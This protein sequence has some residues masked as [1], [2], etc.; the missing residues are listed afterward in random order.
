[1]LL[2]VNNSKKEHQPNNSHNI[3]AKK[4]SNIKN[5]KNKSL[6]KLLY[7]NS[8]S[9]MQFKNTKSKLYKYNKK[10][11][12]KRNKSF[13][14]SISNFNIKDT[15]LSKNFEGFV[16]TNM[17][18]KTPKMKQR[19]NI[20][21]QINIKKQIKKEK[22]FFKK[23]RLKQLLT[24]IQDKR[25]NNSLGNKNASF[26]KYKSNVILKNNS[27]KNNLFLKE[28]VRSN[29]VINL[30]Y[31][32]NMKNN[33]SQN[34][35]SSFYQKS[36]KKQNITINRYL[37]NKN[38]K[39][40]KSNHKGKGNISYEKYSE[41]NSKIKLKKSLIIHNRINNCSNSRKRKNNSMILSEKQ[42]NLLK[43]L[44]KKNKN[45]YMKTNQGNSVY[46]KNN[47]CSQENIF[48][49][50]NYNNFINLNYIDKNYNINNI[51]I[52]NRQPN[53]KSY[54]KIN[55][56]IIN[57][58]ANHGFLQRR[59][60]NDLLDFL[61]MKIK[62]N[63][64]N[65]ST[66]QS[67]DEISLYELRK[68]NSYLN[69]FSY[70][71]SYNSISPEFSKLKHILEYKI[72]PYKNN[73]IT[74]HNFR[75]HQGSKKNKDKDNIND[76]KNNQKSKPKNKNIS[77][78]KN[79][80]SINNKTNSDILSNISIHLSNLS[81][82]TTKN[83]SYYISE[84]QNLSIYIKK[85]FKEKGHYPKSNLNFYKYGRIL[86]K[87]AFGKVNLALHIA[88]GKL[89]AI[90]SFDK[91]KLSKENSIKKIMNEIEVL[92]K[93]RNNIFCT[94]IYDTFQT[95]THILIVMEFICADLLDFIRKREKLDEKKA[96]IIFK[97]IVLGLKNM[98]K[99]N[100][101]HRDIK[102]DNLLLDLTNT[103]KICDFGVSKII[104]SENEIMQDHCGT[105][106][107]IAPEVFEDLGYY[108]YGCDIWSLGVTLYYMLEG[109]QPFKG[110]SIEELKKNICSKNYQNIELISKEAEDLLDKM[111][112][113]NPEERITL[114]EILKHKWIKDVDIKK[115]N[116]MKLFSKHEK[117][118]LEKYNV[119]YFK[120]DTED[121]IENFEQENLNTIETGEKNGNTKSIILAPYNTFVTIYNEP[122]DYINNEIK[123]ENNICK[124]KGDAQVSDIKYQMSN[125]DKFDNGVIKTIQAC[126]ISSLSSFSQNLK[127]E[128]IKSSNNLSSDNI[129]K[130]I[131]NNFCEDI[132]QEIEDKV[133]YDKN[134]L[135]QCLKNDEVNYAT[136]TYYLMLKDKEEKCDN[137]NFL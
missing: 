97:Q 19:I 108:G 11:D 135:I 18:Q 66:L 70:N 96:K 115:R 74:K 132:I 6:N 50:N 41:N 110:R 55:Q 38:Y 46:K 95:D 43:K 51:N 25:S 98:H 78:D 77:N 89:V 88:S 79:K 100:I 76:N 4:I 59:E 103:I 112:T 117:Y 62:G 64:N 32:G 34:K 75:N 23:I 87:G 72:K 123:I 69:L 8:S 45:I 113:L 86:G 118:L 35:Y 134:Y 3:I 104:H 101:V 114:D 119:C 5:K 133:G 65:I 36:N 128:E 54:K 10:N 48:L 92:K 129:N 40:K 24:S 73:K 17:K 68:I 33:D 120:D 47:S 82:T 21:N 27:S 44:F 52:S 137:N 125:N 53:I 39:S 127:T 94:K 126:S 67:R 61:Q 13:N 93:L 7:N 26:T 99:N 107:Y 130:N 106:A 2:L 90:K 1:M 12:Y 20:L 71:S 63:N 15:K 42:G 37:N 105:P 14:N 49:N 31:Y 16:S 131:E 111:L 58:K 57:K 136:A 121:L 84:R 56:K 9:S 80:I 29:N 124:Y 81:S 85:Y 109:E 28:G 102:L 91:K 60:N 116:K 122:N 30:K 22:S 83:K